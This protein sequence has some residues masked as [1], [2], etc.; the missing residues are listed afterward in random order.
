MSRP[1]PRRIHPSSVAEPG[2]NLRC[3]GRREELRQPP[4]RRESSLQPLRIQA[5]DNGPYLTYPDMMKGETF[6]PLDLGESTLVEPAY[7]CPV[8]RSEYIAV[9]RT[10]GGP[11]WSAIEQWITLAYG[12]H[13]DNERIELEPYSRGDQHLRLQ[14]AIGVSKLDLK[15]E[16]GEESITEH[17]GQI[18]RAMQGL[19]VLGQGSVS[20]DVQ[21]SFGHARPNE[22]VAQGIAEELRRLIGKVRFKRA[23]ATLMELDEKE[24]Q[25]SREHVD[26]LKDKVTYTEYVQS[27]DG[28]PERSEVLHAVLHGIERFQKVL[29]ESSRSRH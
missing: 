3:T 6:E 7:I 17:E 21:V 22:A 16:P 5:P 25:I 23:Q 4:Q 14:R 27:N 20:V 24:Q 10:S 29:S 11:T 1:V 26:F 28:P 18:A 12:K 19:Q 15:L 9:L 13:F 8:P 2:A